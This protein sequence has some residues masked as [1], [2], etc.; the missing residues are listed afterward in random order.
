VL[1]G[2]VILAMDGKHYD[3]ICA[4][5]QG[6]F[7]INLKNTSLDKFSYFNRGKVRQNKILWY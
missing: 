3:V 6:R 2:I 1:A 7:I 5:E 4:K